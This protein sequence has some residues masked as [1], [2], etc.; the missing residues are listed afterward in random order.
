MNLIKFR[1]GFTLIELLVVI[2]II[3]ILIGLLLPAVQRVR[4]AS[5]RA[6][7]ANNMKQI[8]LAVHNYE[9]T[10]S[11]LPPS[12]YS[13]MF[14]TTNPGPSPPTGAGNAPVTVMILPYLEQEQL[15]NKCITYDGVFAA[16]NDVNVWQMLMTGTP[17]GR[18]RTAKVKAFICPSDATINSSG[19]TATQ[20]DWGSMSYIYSYMVF[21]GS[22]KPNTYVG[23][24]GYSNNY[25]PYTLASLP[26]GTSNVIGFAEKV[27]AC[28]NTSGNNANSPA[29]LLGPG[30][31]DSAGT[32]VGTG[33]YGNLWMYP[34]SNR[35]WAPYLGPQSGGL[36]DQTPQVGVYDPVKCDNIGI[37]TAHSAAKV[38]MMDG[39][40]RDINANITRVTLNRALVPND[41]MPLGSDW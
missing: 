14:P 2:A 24:N 6:T 25:S 17:N 7:C 40:V 8:G 9:N 1:K 12:R 32:M 41:G 23:T 33:G 5:N 15:Y 13:G 22:G 20:G 31:N 38:L 29:G 28:R 16:M 10:F 18:T 39:G 34:G 4:E 35:D 26:D 30:T 36:W 19:L 11:I 21:G 3:A 37:S 27:G